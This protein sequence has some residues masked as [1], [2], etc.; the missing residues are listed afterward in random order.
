M[1]SL[2]RSFPTLGRGRYQP[3]ILVAILASA[4]FNAYS[5]TDWELLA[6]KHYWSPHAWYYGGY[7][8][9][10]L[11]GNSG[12]RAIHLEAEHNL[13]NLEPL[14][15][16][17]PFPWPRPVTGF[18]ATERLLGPF[19]V[20]V[21]IRASGGAVD[22]SDAFWLVNLSLW[23]LAIVMAYHLA[24]MFFEDQWSPVF[25]ALVCAAYPTFPLTVTSLKIQQFGTVYLLGGVFLYERY[26][27]RCHAVLRF[28]CL[29]GLV[30]AGLFASGGWVFLTVYIAVRQVWR[31]E[32][33]RWVNLCLFVAAVWV[34][35]AGLSQL[36]REYQLPSVDQYLRIDYRSIIAESA[37]WVH[38]WWLGGDLREMKLLNYSGYGLFQ[39]FLPVIWTGFY[40]GHAVLLVTAAAA[41]VL[42]ARARMLVA[43]AVPM[44]FAG[45]A[46]TMLTGWQWH[47]GYLSAPAAVLLVLASSALFGHLASSPSRWRQS[48]AVAMLCVTLWSLADLKMHAGLYWGGDPQSYRAPVLVYQEGASA[49]EAY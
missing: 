18:P 36:T 34:A 33:G 20:S 11:S 31:A 22:I 49:P 5:A 19:A 45:H 7:A 24:S 27:I 38:A 42:L 17:G 6:S 13:L 12:Y 32:P 15:E 39:G 47:Y 29:L 30:W 1:F 21:V 25:A 3:A 46:G 9:R 16:T 48:V 4:C 2:S 26:V 28:L 10:L 44:F 35:Q 41:C 43:T 14:T 40:R 37:G 8:E 23:L